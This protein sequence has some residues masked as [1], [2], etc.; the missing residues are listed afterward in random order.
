MTA[1]FTNSL[2]LPCLNTQGQV[3]S[4]SG[5]Q[6]EGVSKYRAH[7]D[8]DYIEQQ[9]GSDLEHNRRP[10]TLHL[11]GTSATTTFAFLVRRLG[12]SVIRVGFY[13]HGVA[14]TFAKFPSS[15]L[16]YRIIS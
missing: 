16:E 15:E 2:R 8:L 7:I 5:V 11:I 9:P 1:R 12:L 10:P 3:S 14:Q 6:T 13:Q 4:R